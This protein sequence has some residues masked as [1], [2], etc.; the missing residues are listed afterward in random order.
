MCKHKFIQIKLPSSRSSKFIGMIRYSTKG[1]K[2]IRFFPADNLFSL[3]ITILLGINLL[4]QIG[5]FKKIP[6]FSI[7]SWRL[8][9]PTIKISAPE[10]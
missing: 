2:K 1:S 7:A 10:T 5:M 6:H 4:G 9:K 8:T 3:F